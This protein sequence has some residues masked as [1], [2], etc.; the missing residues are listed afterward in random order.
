M[1]KHIAIRL[2]I[3]A[4]LAVVSVQAAADP[5]SSATVAREYRQA[6]E[7]QLVGLYSRSG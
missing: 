1:N 6:H 3:W 2:V 5:G 7:Q 4:T